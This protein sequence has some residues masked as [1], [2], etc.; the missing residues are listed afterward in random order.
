MGTK[1]KQFD[2]K[3]MMAPPQKGV[4]YGGGAQVTLIIHALGEDGRLYRQDGEKWVQ[5]PEL[6]DSET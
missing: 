1:I 3:A 2:I 6:P 5:L 4:L